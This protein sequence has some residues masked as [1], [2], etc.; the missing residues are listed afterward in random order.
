MTTDRSPLGLVCRIRSSMRTAIGQLVRVG[1]ALAQGRADCAVVARP[2]ATDARADPSVHATAPG[3][4]PDPRLTL[5]RT[6]T[7][8]ALRQCVGGTVV[9]ERK[10]ATVGIGG[11]G[12]RRLSAEHGTQIRVGD[13]VGNDAGFCPGIS[14]QARPAH[15]ARA[16]AT[17]WAVVALARHGPTA[18]E[19]PTVCGRKNRGRVGDVRAVFRESAGADR[20]AHR[21]T[22]AARTAGVSLGDENAVRVDLARL[23]VARRSYGECRAEAR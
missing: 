7:G 2:A 10:V 23:I 21:A 14:S 3:D 4:R 8:E 1:P 16:A 15:M 19:A 17:E 12:A 13:G 22:Q 5:R 9:P 18:A 20:R 6:G 11:G